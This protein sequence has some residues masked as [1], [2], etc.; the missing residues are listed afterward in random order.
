MTHRTAVFGLGIVTV[1]WG[2]SFPLMK[3]ANLRMA[4]EH[5]ISPAQ[6]ETAEFAWFTFQSAMF[7]VALR[8]GAAFV[9]LAATAPKLVRKP[10]W[11]EWGP[12]LAIG[13]AFFVGIT[14]QNAGLS[15]IPA[16]R[17]GF[18]TSLAIVFTPFFAMM[19]HRRLPTLLVVLSVL[20][21]LGGT[22]VLTGQLSFAQ[23]FPR[24]AADSWRKLAIG[25]GLTLLSAVLFAAQIITLDHFGKG[26]DAARFTPAMFASA[27]LLAAL[28]FAGSYWKAPSP[29]WWKLLIDPPFLVVLAALVVF[30]SIVAFLGMNRYQ[31]WIS[32]EQAAVVY[33]LEPIFATLWAVALPAMIA[34]QLGVEYPSEK[35]NID[36][37]I[38]GG[39][40]LV[41]TFFCLVPENKKGERGA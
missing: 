41:A 11:S 35:L 20:L 3:L 36:F 34:P 27:S 33:T 15:S 22:A 1:V 21:A 25:D 17:S 19:L 6:L 2:L 12:G 8:F 26:R 32:A 30:C 29:A 14:L 16:S 28:C 4:R 9:L 31:P 5:E 38:G 24:F 37:W 39:L 10:K 7:L 13:T 40:I 18:L 23:G